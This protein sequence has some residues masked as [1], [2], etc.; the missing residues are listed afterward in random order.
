VSVRSAPD[1]AALLAPVIAQLDGPEWPAL[2]ARLEHIAGQRYRAWAK[3]APQHARAL[4]ECADREDDISARGAKLFALSEAQRARVDAFLPGVRDAYAGLF[5]GLALRE[6]LALQAAA[7]RQGAA[8]W[9]A[10]SALPSLGAHEREAV[11]ELARLEEAN[12]RQLEELL[13]SKQI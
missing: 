11:A 9:R 8:A 12:A 13:A 1:I 3:L 10:I 2:L 4:L 7:E 5:S 6:E